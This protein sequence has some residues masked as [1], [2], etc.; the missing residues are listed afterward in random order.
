M[1]GD[2][3]VPGDY[4]GDGKTDY[5]IFR[6]STGTWYII[7][8]STGKSVTQQWGAAGDIPVPGDYD[9]DGKT[10]YAI[11]RPSTGTWY[12]IPSSTGKTVSQVWG[13]RTDI[14]VPADY[15]GDKKTDYAVWRP[16]T[17][18]W[19]VVP[20]STPSKP[21]T[22]SWGAQGDVPIEKPLPLASNAT[23]N[24]S[25]TWLGTVSF[26]GKSK[27][28]TL[29]LIGLETGS[30]FAGTLT[31]SPSCSSSIEMSGTVTGS[32]VTM[33]GSSP[34]GTTVNVT[35]TIN[36]SLSSMSGSF[37]STGGCSG[38]LSGTW[39]LTFD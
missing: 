25:G 2:I 26:N 23:I 10:D 5:A 15:D 8:S 16:S 36:S 19:Y 3:P 6:P 37:S 18:F 28:L 38:S 35:G 29:D 31:V 22:T 21:V 9:G 30:L 24:L 17:G 14:P 13:V 11:W 34:D 4:D 32:N 12:V 33:V 20:S 1:A 27:D 39:S 7:D